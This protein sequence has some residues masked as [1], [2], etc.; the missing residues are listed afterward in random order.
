MIGS[1][2]EL[3]WPSF[4]ARLSNEGIGMKMRRQYWT[5]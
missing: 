2:T 1:S 5:T 3:L 4:S